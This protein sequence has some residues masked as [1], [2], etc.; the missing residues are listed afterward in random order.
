MFAV[1]SQALAASP[2]IELQ[3]LEWHY[4]DSTPQ[5]ATAGE[6]SPGFDALIQ[7]G[8]VRAEVAGFA[9]DYRAAMGSVQNF[10]QRIALDN[11]VAESRY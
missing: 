11:A 6:P 4:G 9:G 1:V 2:D 10:L 7:T 8:I 5:K 3:A